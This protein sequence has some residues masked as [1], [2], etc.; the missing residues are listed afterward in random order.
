MAGKRKVYTVGRDYRCI[1]DWGATEVMP[2][3]IDSSRPNVLEFPLYGLNGKTQDI[4]ELRF[5]D[6]A[7]LRKGKKAVKPHRHSVDKKVNRH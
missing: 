4:L 7:P 1:Y 2:I 5:R 3:I 6:D